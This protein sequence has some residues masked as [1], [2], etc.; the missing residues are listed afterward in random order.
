M[1]EEVDRYYYYNNS[2][3]NLRN[4]G[5]LYYVYGVER[6]D[7][8]NPHHPSSE[9]VNVID[10][11]L[12]T[13]RNYWERNYSKPLFRPKLKKKIDFSIII[14]HKYWRYHHSTSLD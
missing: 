13:L 3:F 8:F 11:Y 1:L 6:N 12:K 14:D 9:E 5:V 2:H 7:V 4:E 10:E